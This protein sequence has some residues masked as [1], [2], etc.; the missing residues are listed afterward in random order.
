MGTVTGWVRQVRAWWE[1]SRV[2]RASA[3]YGQAGGTVLA[4][5]IAYTALFSVFAALTLGF[6]VLMAVLGNDEHLRDRVVDALAAMLPGL[7]DTG[8]GVGV[9]SPA[10]LRLSVGFTVAGVVA[11]VM[12]VWTALRAVGALQAG[13]RTMFGLLPN[14]NVLVSKLRQLGV[15]AGFGLVVV[16]AALTSLVAVWAWDWLRLRH[17]T[18]VSGPHAAGVVA[19]LF[20]DAV[21]F[22]LIVRVLAGARPPR[23]DLLWGALLAALGLGVLR[24]LGTSVVERAAYADPLLASF[25]AVVL[26]LLWVN[27]MARVT[28]YAAAWTADPPPRAPSTAP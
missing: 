28:L 27:M 11:V 25:A 26:L 20:V 24:V 2:G 14:K 5:G 13:V 4:A 9:V 6:A 16:A 10:S 1:R 7:I 12:M 3:R 18:G 23:R 17:W 22:V 8:G 21:T 19:A 15:L